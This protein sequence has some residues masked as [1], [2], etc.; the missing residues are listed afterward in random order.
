MSCSSPRHARAPPRPA[1][2]RLLPC[3]RPSPLTTTSRPLPSVPRP[4]PP[5]HSPPLLSGPFELPIRCRT[6]RAKLSLSSEALDFGA[7]VTLGS[8]ASKTFTLANDGALEVRVCVCVCGRVR[9]VACGVVC[10]SAC[11]LARGGAGLREGSVGR[12][13]RRSS[14]GCRALP[15]RKRFAPAAYVWRNRVVSS[16]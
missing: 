5:L 8:S 13:R 6:K 10:G 14:E 7:G 1:L 4:P 2:P 16:L 15:C 9:V 11:V 12:G 3:V